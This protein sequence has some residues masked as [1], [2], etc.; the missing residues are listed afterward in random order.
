VRAAPGLAPAAAFA[1]RRHAHD[2]E[3]ARAARLLKDAWRLSPQPEIAQAFAE[4]APEEDPAAR[5][6][7]FRDLIGANPDHDES[8][9]LAAELA[10]A[11]SDWRGARKAMGDL[12]SEKPTHRSLALMAAIEKGEGGSEAVVRGYLARAVSAPRG[13]HWVCD[14]CG[15][16]PG[17]WSALCG[18]CKGFDTLEWRDGPSGDESMGAAML[19]LMMDDPVE[20]E[21]A[22]ERD[23]QDRLDDEAV[24]EAVRESAGVRG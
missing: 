4:L 16:A 18:A 17:E 6:R 22:A 5:R 13:A 11:D 21:S 20:P 24:E 8:R 14:R 1:A 19:P 9:Y 23:E 3:K 10:I 12:P 2:G 7:R 15:A